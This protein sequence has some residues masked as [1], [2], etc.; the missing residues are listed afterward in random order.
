M[1]DVLFANLLSN[2]FPAFQQCVYKWK[3]DKAFFL[4]T[5][6][7]DNRKK[8]A[9]MQPYIP[10]RVVFLKWWV[11]EGFLVGVPLLRQLM[12]TALFFVIQGLCFLANLGRGTS[13]SGARHDRIWE[14]VRSRLGRDTTAF[15]T[16]F[17]NKYRIW[18]IG[19]VAPCFTRCCHVACAMWWIYIEVALAFG[20]E[21]HPLKTSK[22]SMIFYCV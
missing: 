20:T 4:M 22:A 1:E 15:G 11:L 14:E 19:V 17:A 10:R 8:R 16:V 6:Q 5:L 7:Q 21:I 2:I 9:A 12:L 18:F 13:E 3:A